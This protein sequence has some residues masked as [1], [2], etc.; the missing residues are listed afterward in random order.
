MPRRIPAH[1]R[2]TLP[3]TDQNRLPKRGNGSQSPPTRPHSGR[4]H[5]IPTHDKGS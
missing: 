5:P 3:G 4:P 2:H 1:P